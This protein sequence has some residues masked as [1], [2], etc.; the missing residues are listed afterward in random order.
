V[1]HQGATNFQTKLHQQAQKNSRKKKSHMPAKKCSTNYR[2]LPTQKINKYQ[3]CNNNNN[4]PEKKSYKYS[5][6]EAIKNQGRSAL[7]KNQQTKSS[8]PE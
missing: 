3:L 5:Y 8:V 2:D 7:Y 6:Q 1:Y 4:T